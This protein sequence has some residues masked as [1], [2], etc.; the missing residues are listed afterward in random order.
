LKVKESVSVEIWRI[1]DFLLERCPAA[2]KIGLWIDV[3]G[4][5]ALVLDG[6]EKI[7]DRV[8]AVHV[9]TA[10][11]AVWEG[12]KT[13]SDLTAT[14]AEKGYL[15][16]GSNFPKE[17]RAGDVVFVSREAASALGKRLLLGRMKAYLSYWLQADNLAVYLKTRSPWLYRTLRRLLIRFGT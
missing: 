10:R 2:R 7:R 5:E 11:T 14:M 17:V 4:A 1:D 16:C 12:Q 6:M 3:E 8:I 13:L 9:E 15:L